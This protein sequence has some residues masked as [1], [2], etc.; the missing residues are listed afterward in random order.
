MLSSLR[1]SRVALVGG[2]G[3]VGDSL[4]AYLEDQSCIHCVIDTSHSTK[5]EKYIYRTDYIANI[6]NEDDICKIF[7]EFL[8]DIVVH[9]ASYGMSGPAMLD[10]ICYAINYGGTQNLIS[11]CRRFN[12]RG[13]I[14]ASTYNVIFGGQHIDGGCEK[15]TYF[16]GKHSDQYAPSK[17]LAEKLVIACNCAKTN[18]GSSLMTCSLRLC[19]IYGPGE[20]RH[21]P[22]IVSVMDR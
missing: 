13:L 7:R 8:P 22:R 5:A 12:V 1:N 4:S 9:L 17:T 14:Y 6:C 2:G 16:L 15:T 19:A 20:K 10:P 21:F 3:F 18:N 11:A